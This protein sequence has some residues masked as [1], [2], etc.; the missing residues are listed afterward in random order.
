MKFRCI[1]EVLCLQGLQKKFWVQFYNISVHKKMI[2]FACLNYY[3][4]RRNVTL[5]S[6]IQTPFDIAAK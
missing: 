5:A 3:T 4:G 6:V 2:T 1:L